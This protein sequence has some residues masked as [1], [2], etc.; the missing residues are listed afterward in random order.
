MRDIIERQTFVISANLFYFRIDPITGVEDRAEIQSPM[1][2][3]FAA[4]EMI[5]KSIVYNPFTFDQQDARVDLL[6][7]VQIWCNITNDGLIGVFPNG[8]TVFQQHNEHFRLNNTFQTGN[9][10]IQFQETNNGGP[11]FYNPQ[12]LISTNPTQSTFG[13]VSI[14]IEFIK[15]DK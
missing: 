3:R 1:N 12:P 6:N 15:Y 5:L 4:D 10:I 7:N 9:V 14:T 2:L 11:F 13:V 8:F